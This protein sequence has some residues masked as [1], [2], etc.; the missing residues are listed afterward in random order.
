[1]IPTLTKKG[2]FARPYCRGEGGYFGP[3]LGGGVFHDVPSAPLGRTFFDFLTSKPKIFFEISD[4][5]TEI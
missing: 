3:Y 4:F 5:L 2:G 1:M